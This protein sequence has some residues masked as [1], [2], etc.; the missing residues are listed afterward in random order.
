[1]DGSGTV[2]I[3]GNM[4]VKVVAVDQSTLSLVWVQTMRDS[5]NE[6]DYGR[7][8]FS[9]L[10]GRNVKSIIATEFLPLKLAAAG[11]YTYWWT[12]SGDIY[13]YEMNMYSC[14]I[15]TGNHFRVHTETPVSHNIVIDIF[16]VC[17]V[18]PNGSQPAPFWNY[19]DGQLCSHICVPTGTKY[20]RC[21]CPTAGHA[22]MSNGWTCGKDYDF[23]FFR[24]R[25]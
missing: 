15:S 7:M 10:N 20:M 13:S 17:V 3:I 6:K 21:L 2:Q 14:Q 8:F 5:L 18:S 24:S 11:S 22:L 25:C 4:K 23:I 1:M 19:C 12:I 9:D 16:D